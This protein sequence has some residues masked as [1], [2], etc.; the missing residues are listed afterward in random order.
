MI[1]P[2]LAEPRNKIRGFAIMRRK[3]EGKPGSRQEGGGRNQGSPRR[4]ARAR[5]RAG[6]GIH[7]GAYSFHRPTQ[8]VRAKSWRRGRRK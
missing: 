2:N 8:Q 1:Q 3:E 7:L 4:Q 5:A 6:E